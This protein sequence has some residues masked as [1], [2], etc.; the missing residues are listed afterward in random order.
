ML[1]RVRPRAEQ[2]RRARGTARGGRRVERRGA[3]GIGDVH[4]GA[5]TQQPG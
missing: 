5:A 3:V 2:G 4:G 1:R